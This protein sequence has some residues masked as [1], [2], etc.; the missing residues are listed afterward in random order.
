[1]T[2]QASIQDFWQAHPC[3]AELVGDLN[4]E[5]RAEYQQFFDRYD[6]YRYNKEPHILKNLDRIDWQEKRVLEIGL[7]QGADAEQIAKRGG[8]Y[9]GVDLTDESVKRVRMR[10]ALKDLPF[11]RIE[12]AS[13]LDL[14]FD[15]NAFDVVFSHG[16]LHH[17]PEIRSAQ[18][19]IA[20]VLKRDGSLIVM[21]YAKWSV[22]YLLA[23]S[24]V[25]RLGLAG[26]YVSRTRPGGIYNDHLDNAKKV[27]LGKYL[28]MQNFV[29]VSTDGPFNPYSKVYDRGEIE[30]DFPAF[31]IVETHKEFMHAPPLPIGWLPLAG[32]LGWHLW[33]TMRAKK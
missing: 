28:T 17:I 4:E 9:S 7:G 27:G 26:L 6:E 29:N 23:I 1:M 11:D 15:D 24:V 25:R 21:L 30:R 20:R 32:A 14:P 12:Q 5:T 13:A 31:D 33:A 3:G 16:V 2:T 8:I 19:E 22:N 10:F 18:A